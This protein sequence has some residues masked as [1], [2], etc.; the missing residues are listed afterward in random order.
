MDNRLASLRRLLR[1]HVNWLTVKLLGKEIV[2]K[3]DLSEL[4]DY[5][6]LPLGDEVGLVERSFILGRTSATGKKSDYKDLTLDKL[7]RL[8]KR[9]FSNAEQLALR[10]A[11]LHTARRIQAIADD[12]AAGASARVNDAT[13]ELLTDATVKQILEDEIAI[14]LAED[15]TRKQLA[16][17]VSNALG[18]D[19]TSGLK[20]LMVTEMHRAKTRGVAMAIANKVDIYASSDGVESVVSVVPNREACEDCRNLYLTETGNPRIFKLS[21]LIGQGSNSDSGVSHSRKGGLHLGW[22]PVLPPAH[23]NCYC[24]L[25]FVPPGMAWENGRLRVNDE[26]RYKNQISKAVDQ[27]SMSATIKPK[28]APSYQN[29]DAP[30]VGSLKGV[31][32]PNRE[33]RPP[34]DQAAAAAPAPQAAKAPA[35]EAVAGSADQKYVPCPYGGDKACIAHGGQGGKTHKRGGEEMVK[36]EQYDDYPGSA[37]EQEL[38]DPAQEAEELLGQ[39]MR[40]EEFKFGS[41]PREQEQKDLSTGDIA[42]RRDIKD[43]PEVN[44]VGISTQQVKVEK[45]DIVENGSGLMKPPLLTHPHSASNEV[46]GACVHEMYGSPNNI[47]GHGRAPCTT[48]RV[49]ENEKKSVQG[50]IKGTSDGTKI[51]EDAADAGDVPAK[52]TKTGTVKLILE[53]SK[54][55]EKTRA[56]IEET[57]CAD[58][59]MCNTDRHIGNMLFDGENGYAIDHGHAFGRGMSGLRNHYHEGMEGLGMEVHVPA[60]MRAKINNTSFDQLY[61]GLSEHT[62]LW[63][64]AQT[65]IRGHYLLHVEDRYGKIPY[66]DIGGGDSHGQMDRL[67]MGGRPAY[68]DR[69]RRFDSGNAKFEAFA[70]KWIDERAADPSHP[71]HLA[72]KQFQEEGIFMD[73]V[74]DVGGQAGRKQG[75]RERREG[76]HLKYEKFAR[77]HDFLLSS[78]S[79]DKFAINDPASLIDSKI[80]LE[81]QRIDNE[82]DAKVEEINVEIDSIV[83]ATKVIKFPGG[84][85][86]RNLTQDQTDWLAA[87]GKEIQDL[88]FA[89]HRLERQAK[90]DKLESRM[91]IVSKVVPPGQEEIYA[92]L[93]KRI[94]DIGQGK[95]PGLDINLNTGVSTKQADDSSQLGTVPITFESAAASIESKKQGMFARVLDK[96][97]GK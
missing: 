15:K 76:K 52:Q 74:S 39:M 58:I 5:G 96:V 48:Y 57:C 55:K 9:K 84:G 45:I 73:L 25:T 67:S 79:Y 86:N 10:E 19:L 93:D 62:T 20:K 80:N 22:K 78:A 29:N 23:P 4:K 66:K 43:V 44:D 89:A 47:G 90:L 83:G 18:R 11:K 38:K 56:D 35:Q 75:D 49:D 21:D 71:D 54:N 64:A 68:G 28:G 50:W 8:Q 17:T 16:N 6:R 36:H 24:E 69:S 13:Q 30:K 61:K 1:I 97:K 82:M 3:E 40:I 81:A 42:R 33:G 41:K 94:A 2:S 12:A 51:Y 95:K 77:S 37:E 32:E 53:R 72:A 92:S 60:A 70:F 63:R 59:I 7:S 88:R 91:E 46:G 14:A 26:L 31:S 27:G 87:K 65:Y 34:A 85:I